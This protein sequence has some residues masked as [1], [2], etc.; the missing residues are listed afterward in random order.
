MEQEMFNR[1]VEKENE[2]YLIRVM[3]IKIS[4]LLIKVC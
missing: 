1:R 4:E 2:I 3:K